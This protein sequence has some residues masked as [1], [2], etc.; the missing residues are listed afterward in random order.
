M[1]YNYLQNYLI[2]R[3]NTHNVTILWLMASTFQSRQD[4]IDKP[5]TQMHSLLLLALPWTAFTNQTVMPITAKTMF[6]WIWTFYLSGW[7]MF[8]L[9]DNIS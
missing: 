7:I 6:S 9:N 5:S 8:C 2:S 4:Y 3:L 1:A